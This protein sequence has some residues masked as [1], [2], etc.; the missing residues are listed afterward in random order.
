MGV[1]L[2]LF[3]SHLMIYCFLA[4]DVGILVGRMAFV[5]SFHCG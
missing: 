3:L 4:W 2:S 5:H 1:Q